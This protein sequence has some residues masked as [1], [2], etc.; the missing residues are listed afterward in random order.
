[1]L[2]QYIFSLIHACSMCSLYFLPLRMFVRNRVPYIRYHNENLS[3][4]IIGAKEKDFKSYIKVTTGKQCNCKQC[5][6]TNESM[7]SC[8]KACRAAQLITFC[9]R[10]LAAVYS[11]TAWSFTHWILSFALFCFLSFTAAGKEHTI[12]TTALET[13]SDVLAQVVALD[14]QAS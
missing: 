8:K 13:D 5:R 3:V 7:L 12:D 4:N 6:K 14:K 9:N 1:M 10:L 11:L 2:T